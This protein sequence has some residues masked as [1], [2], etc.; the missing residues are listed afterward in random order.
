MKELNQNN[1]D[2]KTLKGDDSFNDSHEE[3]NTEHHGDVQTV[4]GR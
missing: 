2:E 3:D 1:S 4:P